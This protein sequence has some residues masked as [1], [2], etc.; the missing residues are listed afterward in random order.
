LLT[1]LRVIN[2]VKTSQLV[3]VG[4]E[5]RVRKEV[6]VRLQLQLNRLHVDAEQERRV[7][8]RDVF[9]L[10]IGHLM[11]PQ[12]PESE[13]TLHDGS[14]FLHLDAI[15][16]GQGLVVGAGEHREATH[17]ALACTVSSLG[18]RSF[19]PPVSIL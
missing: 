11:V 16:K 9:R 10:F 13:K 17:Y 14:K 4:L 3:H 6:L 1:L 18:V 8:L 12:V 2:G 15:F 7:H 19:K 5:Q